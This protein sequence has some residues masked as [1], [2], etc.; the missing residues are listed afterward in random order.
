MQE[1]PQSVLD[2]APRKRIKDLSPAERRERRKLYMRERRAEEKKEKS[3]DASETV[4]QF[5]QVQR[6]AL[7]RS[8]PGKL[9]EWQA[10]QEVV[11]DHVHWVRHQLDGSYNDPASPHYCDPND[12]TV[13]VG[14]A[15]GTADLE[16]DIGEHGICQTEILA[17]G[18]FWRD[19]ELYASL[20]RDGD[21]DSIFAQYGLLTA[22][23]GHIHHEFQ[24]FITRNSEPSK[25]AVSY[26]KWTTIQCV[27]GK[28]EPI[29]QPISD[30]YR[31]KGIRYLCSPCRE[32][33]NNSRAIARGQ[34]SQRIYDGFGRI[35]DNNL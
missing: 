11:L 26:D 33:E 4:E 15:E 5:W 23:P 10:R 17:L 16:D 1:A 24:K 30:D 13:Y 27:C 7:E 18:Q 28:K 32:S 9:A 35:K 19:A 21:A 6:A 22:V 20:L 12:P 8:D 29:A 25:T 14:L 3:V 2:D 34:I 31:N